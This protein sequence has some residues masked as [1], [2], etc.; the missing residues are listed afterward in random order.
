[1]YFFLEYN[2]RAISRRAKKGLTA[3][4]S[5]HIAQYGFTIDEGVHF[6]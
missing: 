4:K 3:L 1:M 2:A 5:T 6:G